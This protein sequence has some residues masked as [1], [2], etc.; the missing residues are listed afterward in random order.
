MNGNETVKSVSD[1]GY[2]DGDCYSGSM[3]KIPAGQPRAW[4]PTR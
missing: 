3:N 4:S 1:D 2:A